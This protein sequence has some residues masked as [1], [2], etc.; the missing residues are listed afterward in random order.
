MNPKDEQL[1]LLLLLFENEQS[2]I[3]GLVYRGGKG[4]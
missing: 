4:R 3:G 2:V 1:L